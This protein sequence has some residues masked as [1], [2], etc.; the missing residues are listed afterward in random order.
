ML[1]IG[2][3]TL[4][5]ASC[6]K[7]DEVSELPTPEPEKDYV[8]ADLAL[9]LPAASFGT[10]M[11][12]EVVQTNGSD[13]RGIQRL[14]IIP[15]SK[16]G[17]IDFNDLPTYYEVGNLFDQT[18][19]SNERLRYYNKVILSQGVASFLTYGQA[20]RPSNADKASY[21]SLI[22]KVEGQKQTGNTIP[23]RVAVAP[24]NLTFELEPI[25]SS[26]ETT[27]EAR[28]IA[29]YM[30]VIAESRASSTVRWDNSE[31]ETLKKL[32]RKFVNLKD[33]GVN[34]SYECIAGS[35]ANIKANVNQLYQALVDAHFTD[36][37]P[38]KAIADNIMS[39]IRSFTTNLDGTFDAN[40]NTVTSLGSA[41]NYPSSLGLPDCAAVLRWGRTQEG[42]QAFIPQ[43]E[44][45]T[46][47][48]INS[49][50]RY[51]YPPELY[52][53]GNSVIK[54]S[55]KDVE[56]SAYNSKESWEAVMADAN[57]YPYDNAVVSSNTKAVAIKEPLQ[58]A[59]AHLKAT[60]KANGGT[61]S[62]NGNP[63]K[64]LVVTGNKFP[65]TGI[66]I[67]GQYPVNYDFTSRYDD[68]A[69]EDERFVYDTQLKPGDTFYLTTTAQPF[70][71]LVL[72]GHDNESV[73]VILELENKSGEAFE[74]LN[75]TIYPNT[76]FYL[77]GKIK[78]SA[79]DG[80]EDYKKRVFT[81][82]YTTEADMIVK[83]F[84]NA[85]N[86]MPNIQ[87]SR[88]EVGVEV[89]LKWTQAQPFTFEFDE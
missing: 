76:K 56:S 59:V 40:T 86:V 43:T 78:L 82:D 53:Y 87:T 83:T 36:G 42:Y 23:D 79:P 7:Q 72:Q 52:Y 71:T 10:R 2:L 70:H 85:Y 3:M 48:N 13:F 16:Q 19:I 57:I 31:N 24:S 65:V 58:Y 62:D 11:S 22:A 50:D 55:N 89:E 88:L 44:T 5:L 8:L 69:Y 49:I 12:E 68:V 26:T 27:A 38:E 63:V 51:A 34:I 64:E 61:V 15:F 73:T 28:A 54:A 45:T 67:S 18:A 29:G 20:T 4:I 32:Y 1:T 75:G 21:G 33:D 66:I 77:V 60:L 37:T 30:T 80:T 84:A 39:K 9:S 17:K 6:Q 25:R 14:S 41:D 46:L 74:G 81:Q 47:A 35:S